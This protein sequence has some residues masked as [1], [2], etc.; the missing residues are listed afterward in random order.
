M[1]RIISSKNFGPDDKSIAYVSRGNLRTNAGADQLASADYTEAIRLKKD[2][3]AAYLGRA[4]SQLTLGN[5]NGAIV[6]YSEA[7]RL[8][9]SNDQIYSSAGM[10]ILSAIILTRR[11]PTSASDPT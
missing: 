3:L 9:P 6:D 1:Q 8:A 7:I 4:R 5:R 11:S 2:N 10:L